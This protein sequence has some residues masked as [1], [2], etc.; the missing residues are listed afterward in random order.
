[1][2]FAMVMQAMQKEGLSQEQ[3]VPFF[4]AEWNG[5]IQRTRPMHKIESLGESTIATMSA[6]F[7]SA[8]L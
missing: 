2:T 7:V 1:M 3:L 6:Q 4:K 5:N 8:E